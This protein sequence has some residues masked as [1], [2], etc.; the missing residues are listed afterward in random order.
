MDKNLKDERAQAR[1]NVRIR[2]LAL[3]NPGDSHGVGEGVEE[4]RIDYGPGYRVYFTRRGME[5]VIFLREEI[6]LHRNGTSQAR[7]LSRVDWRSNMGTKTREWDT[8]EFLDSEEKMALYLEAALEEG[9]AGLVAAALGDIT[10]AKGMTE[11]ARESGLGRESLYKALSVDGNPT[12]ATILK[13]IAA[14]GLKLQATPR[15]GA[16]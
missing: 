12:F 10:R 1:V 7:R 15:H 11:I 4:M 8:V 2:R 6:R 9:D 14:L 16:A 5:V 13:V 3:G